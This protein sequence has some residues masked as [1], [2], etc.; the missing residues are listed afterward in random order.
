MSAQLSVGSPCTNSASMSDAVPSYSGRP[1]LSSRLKVG[2]AICR[3]FESLPT[4]LMPRATFPV[5]SRSPGRW[6]MLS[7]KA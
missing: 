4:F 3:A 1:R 2:K 6:P 7:P 5:A